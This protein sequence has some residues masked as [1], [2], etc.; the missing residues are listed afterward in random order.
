MP[1]LPRS[2]ATDG[3]PTAPYK[4]SRQ[5]TSSTPAQRNLMRATSA[6]TG[7]ELDDIIDPV[8]DPIYFSNAD[9]NSYFNI[10]PTLVSILADPVTLDQV[11]LDQ[12][13]VDMV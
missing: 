1:Y 4:I 12:I 7:A 5:K 8:C 10:E 6:D 2:N 13:I 11:T 3:L 9:P